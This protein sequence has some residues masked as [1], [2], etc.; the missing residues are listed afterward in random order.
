M[1]QETIFL[2]QKKIITSQQELVMLFVATTL[3]TKVMEIK[4]S[5]Y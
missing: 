4:M 2:D 1:V 3:S 5:H